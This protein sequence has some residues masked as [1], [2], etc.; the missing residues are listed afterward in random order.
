MTTLVRFLVYLYTLSTLTNNNVATSIAKG[1]QHSSSFETPPMLHDKDINHLTQQLCVNSSLTT[2]ST[3]NCS[4]MICSKDGPMLAFGCCA[5]YSEDT[6]LLSVTKCLTFQSTGYNVTTPGYILL[7]RNLTQLN[8]YMC[9]P[10]NRKGLVCSECADGFGPSVTS[11]RYTCANCTD[12]WYGVPLFLF[13][14]FVPITVFYLIIL[15]FQ[16]SV[17]SAPMPCFIMYAQFIIS[18]L[19]VS[20]Y[21]HSSIKDE[22]FVKDGE[23]RSDMK[24]IY[25]FYG[26][27]NLDFVHFVILPFCVSSKLKIFYTAF[28]GYISV[29]YPVW[30]I[31]LT[32][33][34]VELHDRNFRPL[35][36]MWRPFHRCSVRLRRTWDTKSDIIDV[37]ITFFLLSYSKCL[38]QTVL[39]LVDQ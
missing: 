22:T 24:I 28:F 9:G 32:W 20:F 19:N 26:L 18:I 10:L 3:Y 15:V 31:C 2:S 25:T 29:I 7:P 8:D 36:W 37:F 17:T 4:Q 6:R 39:L 13:L 5:T 38:Y 27:F 33:A 14:E 34:C 16:I 21:S 30:L 11:F 12:A 23:F 1:R 35:V